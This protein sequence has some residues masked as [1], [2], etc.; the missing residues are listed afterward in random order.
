MNKSPTMAI[1]NFY[2]RHFPAHYNLYNSTG[3]VAKETV[4]RV[5]VAMFPNLWSALK[6]AYIGKVNLFLAF[7]F[8][9]L[10]FCTFTFTFPRNV[11]L[12]NKKRTFFSHAFEQR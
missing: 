2:E 1:K 4:F 5:S 3:W 10:K 9:F 7:M 12:N 6:T 11:N 8:T